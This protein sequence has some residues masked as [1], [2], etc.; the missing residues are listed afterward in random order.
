[1]SKRL[2]TKR[3]TKSEVKNIFDIKITDI[4]IR[5]KIENSDNTSNSNK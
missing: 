5:K 2:G 4:N 3:T 1:M